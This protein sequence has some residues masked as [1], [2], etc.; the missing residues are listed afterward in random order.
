MNSKYIGHGVALGVESHNGILGQ[1]KYHDI[2]ASPDKRLFH[3]EGWKVSDNRAL[4]R[5]RE[6]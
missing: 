6:L 1:S 2:G 4:Y 3:C 5:L